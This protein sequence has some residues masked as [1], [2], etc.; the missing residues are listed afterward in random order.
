LSQTPANR[1]N[2]TPQH[3]P[4]PHLQDYTLAQYKPETFEHLAYSQTVRKLTQDFGYP[5]ELLHLDFDW[6]YMMR[7]LTIDKVRG[8]VIKVD[9]HKYV[10]LACHGLSRMSKEDRQAAYASGTTRQ[11]FDNENFTTIDT[12]F[13]LAEAYLFMQIV[14]LKDTLQFPML[15]QK[16]YKD[17]YR[18]IRGAVDLSHRDGSLKAEV[19]ANP[20][21]YI[22]RVRVVACMH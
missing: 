14:D 6:Q 12:L 2:P 4:T 1:Q 5:E 15:I 18:D 11:S 20:G 21:K 7:G 17:I 16:P 9:R 10:K 13:S 19:A 8:N 22:H 3:G